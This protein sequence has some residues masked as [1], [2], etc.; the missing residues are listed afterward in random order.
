MTSNRHAACRARQWSACIGIA[1][2]AAAVT[3][4]FGASAA[5]ADDTSPV[6]LL[7]DAQVALTDA[8]QVLGQVDVASLSDQPLIAQFINSA[9]GIQDHA[10]QIVDKLD[11]A[12]TAILSYDNGALSSLISP[13][14]TNLDQQWSQGS[15]ALLA[16]DQTLSEAIASGSVPDTIAAQVGALLPTVELLGPAYESIPIEWAGAL[17]GAGIDTTNLFS[18]IGL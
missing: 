1:A 7:G 2:G 5:H 13:L 17:V 8:N 10:L 4:I 6:D 18:S 9:T 15:E 14:F 12:E 3:A 16:A 11:S